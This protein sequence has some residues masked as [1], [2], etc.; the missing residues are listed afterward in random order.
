MSGLGSKASLDFKGR[1]WGLYFWVSDLRFSAYVEFR[2]W[3]VE[4]SMGCTGMWRVS[5]FRARET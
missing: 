3:K 4:R 1:V 2:V 5:G